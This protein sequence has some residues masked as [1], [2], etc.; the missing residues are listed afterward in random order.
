[1][2]GGASRGA[3][4]NAEAQSVATLGLAT[5]TR[6]APSSLTEAN[7]DAGSTLMARPIATPIGSG[8]SGRSVRGAR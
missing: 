5:P 4:T 2:A 7:R 8:R 1:M 6:A 3:G